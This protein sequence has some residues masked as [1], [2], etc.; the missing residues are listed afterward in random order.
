VEAVDNSKPGLNLKRYLID[1]E[2]AV[3]AEIRSVFGSGVA[4]NGCHVHMRRNLRRRLQELKHLQTLAVKNVPFN[5]FI[6][7]VSCL[8][9]VPAAE[10][11]DYYQALVA[12][13]LPKVMADVKV[14]LEAEDDDTE[15]FEDI[16][17]SVDK[18]LDYVEVTYIGKVRSATLLSHFLEI[19]KPAAFV[20]RRPD[21]GISGPDLFTSGLFLR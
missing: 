8:A 12:E 3:M 20:D 15:R 13:E 7:A 4:V 21:S 10:V 5:F 1:F 17:K 16:Q 14:Q 9:Y 18:F 2:A 6:S 11:P 19:L